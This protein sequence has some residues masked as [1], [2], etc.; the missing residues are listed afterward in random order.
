MKDD[1]FEVSFRNPIVR[2]WFYI[3]LPTMII[4][5]I[6]FLVLPIES[7]LIIRNVGSVILIGYCIWI[8]LYKRKNRNSE[9]DK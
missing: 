8:F 7:H 9:G 2:M 5:A 1:R 4:S 3:I 6:L